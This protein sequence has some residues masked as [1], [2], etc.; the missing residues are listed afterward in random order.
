MKAVARLSV[1]NFYKIGFSVSD[2]DENDD[3]VLLE[4]PENGRLGLIKLMVYN[5]DG[6]NDHSIQ[7]KNGRLDS[8]GDVDEVEL[9]EEV[10]V[11]SGE[12]EVLID[13][14]VGLTIPDHLVIE[15]SAEEL[16]VSV[17]AVLA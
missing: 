2:E 9:I 12:T 3:V 8:D 10:E 13:A 1:S 11:S 4:K 15:S 6:T 14:N 7:I 17:W 5:S 16:V